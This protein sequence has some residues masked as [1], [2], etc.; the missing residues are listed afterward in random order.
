MTIDI[1]QVYN[2]A[3]SN[4]HG[5]GLAAVWNAAVAD[6]KALFEGIDIGAL[7]TENAALKAQ[8]A[9]LTDKVGTLSAEIVAL[10]PAPVAPVAEATPAPVAPVAEATP[11]PVAPVVE[12]VPGDQHE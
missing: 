3:F 1:Q 9:A 2:N 4:S 7:Q 12:A 8:V 6:T 11:A 5:A 10:T